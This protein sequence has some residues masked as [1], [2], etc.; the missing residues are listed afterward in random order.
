MRAAVMQLRRRIYEPLVRQWLAGG[1][2]PELERELP[3]DVVEDVCR[4]FRQTHEEVMA[5]VRAGDFVDGDEAVARIRDR[6]AK[7]EAAQQRAK[8]SA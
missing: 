7:L 5:E 2:T 1:M 8:R 4:D 6:L 3:A